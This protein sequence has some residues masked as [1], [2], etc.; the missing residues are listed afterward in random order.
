MNF[1]RTVMIK[2]STI[3]TVADD[4]GNFT[5]EVKKGDTLPISY[6]GYETKEIV[7]GNQKFI[8]ATLDNETLHE[9]FIV[10]EGVKRCKKVIIACQTS[11]VKSHILS[12][13]VGCIVATKNFRYM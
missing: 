5:L 2:N 6:T 12:C 4:H 11:A 9:V 1:N 3:G 10:V 8:S 13:T 7:I